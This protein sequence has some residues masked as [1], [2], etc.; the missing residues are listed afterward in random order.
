MINLTFGTGSEHYT[1]RFWITND[2]GFREQQE[3]YVFGMDSK[4]DHEEVEKRLKA[5]CSDIEIIEI[6]YC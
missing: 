1:A 6:T 5:I 2:E 4:N 3:V